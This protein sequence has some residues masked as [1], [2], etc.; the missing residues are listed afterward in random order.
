MAAPRPHRPA[1]SQDRPPP[2][3]HRIQQD[4]AAGRA[5]FQPQMELPRPEQTDDE[6]LR[7]IPRA[8]CFGCGGF[9]QDIIV[10]VKEMNHNG[11]LGRGFFELSLRSP[12]RAASI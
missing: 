9:K 7:R 6:S 11:I 1:W 2:G 5:Q 10:Q 8:S 3:E 12:F 4:T